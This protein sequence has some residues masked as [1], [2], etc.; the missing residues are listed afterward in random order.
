MSKV[1]VDKNSKIENWGL[2]YVKN[3]YIY[4]KDKKELLNKEELSKEK[5]KVSLMLAKLDRLAKYEYEL[6]HSK[7][8]CPHCHCLLPLNGLCDLCD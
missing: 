5:R 3:K 1:I 6:S 8:Y 4:E 7:G 2:N